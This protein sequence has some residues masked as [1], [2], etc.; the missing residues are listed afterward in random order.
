MGIRVFNEHNLKCLT[1][2]KFLLVK[3]MAPPL[4]FYFNY[5][6]KRTTEFR[7]IGLRAKN[8]CFV[9]MLS[10][11]EVKNLSLKFETSSWYY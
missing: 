11:Y 4:P 9:M 8:Y 5:I 2:V 7:Q 3:A 6:V 10:K 1:C